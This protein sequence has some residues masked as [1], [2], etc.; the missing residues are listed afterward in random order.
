LIKLHLDL[1]LLGHI[2]STG[3]ATTLVG[4]HHFTNPSKAFS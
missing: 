4:I 1:F 3:G 2:L